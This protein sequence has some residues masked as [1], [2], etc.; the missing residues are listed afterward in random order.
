MNVSFGFGCNL[1]DLRYIDEVAGRAEQDCL[2]RVRG[3]IDIVRGVY[4]NSMYSQLP[5]SGKDPYCN[6]AP[7]TVS[8][9]LSTGQAEFIAHL[10]ATS[11]RSIFLLLLI[12]HLQVHF[13]KHSG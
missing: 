11:R 2:V 4:R 10:F 8:T 3:M 6:L 9:A 13:L 1:N 7:K 5:S 12:F